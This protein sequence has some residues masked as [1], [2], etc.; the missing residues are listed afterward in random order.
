MEDH[1]FATHAISHCVEKKMACQSVLNKLETVTLPDHLNG[2]HKLERVLV[3]K[4]L[5][6][7]KIVI[8]PKGQSPK[9][10]GNICNVPVEVNDK[11]TT[12][13]REPTNNGFLLVKLKR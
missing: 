1:T 13:P 5:L 2:I 3:S 12:L 8:M 11:V 6:F 7:K 9:L 10:K 4:R